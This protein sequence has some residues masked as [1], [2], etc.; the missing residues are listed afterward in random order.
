MASMIGKWLVF[1]GILLCA[2]TGVLR[3]QDGQF[4]V[5]DFSEFEEAYLRPHSGPVIFNFWATWCKPCVKEMPYFIEL[6]ERHPEWQL[7]LV[8]LD[9]PRHFE[10]RLRPFLVENEITQE[11]VVLDEANANIYID[12]IDP[13]WGGSI[14]ATLVWEKNKIGFIEDEFEDYSQLEAFILQTLN[15][16]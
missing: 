2:G 16:K 14:P 5:M 10:S 9:F 4:T 15:K 3:A 8:S 12:A 13:S 6:E 7:V 1:T 11:V